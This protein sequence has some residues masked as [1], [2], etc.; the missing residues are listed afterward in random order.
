MP[1]I[2]VI[3]KFAGKYAGRY[4]GYKITKSFV[5]NFLRDNVVPEPG[6]VV[7]CKLAVEMEHSGIYTGDGKIVHLDGCGEVKKVTPKQFLKR[8]D[9]MNP[10]LTIYVSSKGKKAVGNREV[11]QR[12]EKKIGDR[13]PYSLTKRNCHRFASGC[14]TGNFEN[15]DTFFFKLEKRAKEILKFDNWRVW[16]R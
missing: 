9:G 6:S 4:V 2:P 11:A 12:A 5:D 14:L 7:Y 13:M 8:L 15:N 10:A 1:L 3:L 16:K